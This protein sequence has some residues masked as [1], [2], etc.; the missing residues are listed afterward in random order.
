MP[1]APP[2]P[3]PPPGR[4]A[5]GTLWS[6]T[7]EAGAGHW[8]DAHGPVAELLGLSP[9][10]LRASP[11]M[12]Q[13]HIVEED[14]PRREAFVRTLASHGSAVAHY[15]L[16]GHDGHLHWI[17]EA[18]ALFTVDGRRICSGTLCECRLADPGEAGESL[19]H[20][21]VN[22]LPIG[23]LIRQR[24]GNYEYVNEAANRL[25]NLPSLD[26]VAEPGLPAGP[27]AALRLLRELDELALQSGRPFERELD[28]SQGDTTARIH[29]ITCP[30]RIG[31]E[32]ISYLCT[33]ATDITR[34]HAVELEARTLGE[35]RAAYADVQRKFVSLV[36]HELRTPLTAIQGAHY[37]IGRQISRLAPDTGAQ[38][39]RL[40][41]LQEDALRVLRELVDQVLML[42]RL[43]HQ[44]AQRPTLS[45]GDARDVIGKVVASFNESTTEPRVDLDDQL[46]AGLA[47]HFDASLLRTA[48]ENLISNALKYSPP[49]RRV[50]VTLSAEGPAWQVAVADAGRGL[51]EA[52]LTKLFQPFFR[53][54]NV[55][56]TPGTGLGLTIVQRV[57]DLHG[58]H[59]DFRSQEGRGT[60]VTLRFPGTPT[61]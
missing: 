27:S 21:F 48:A 10:A 7:G 8:L 28:V 44:V 61:P 14:R 57:M 35:R 24:D 9:E 19:F 23:V 1:S 17:Q 60:T 45:P 50:R 4:P 22:T 32:E 37:L 6:Y 41:R 25:F 51:P 59:V 13:A 26:I 46:P 58:G 56:T 53:A 2:L 20:Q 47:T 31:S 11:A 42:N 30:L 52:E 36:S 29:L 3:A 39:G 55:G 33:L 5:S 15:R 40:L 16:R 38:L 34:K 43:D 54:S 49:D 18:A 12:L